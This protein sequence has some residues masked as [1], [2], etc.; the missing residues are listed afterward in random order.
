MAPK[1]DWFQAIFLPMMMMAWYS[2]N[3]LTHRVDCCLKCMHV[4]HSLRF[5][6]CRKSELLF[7]IVITFALNC[8]LMCEQFFDSIFAT[9]TQVQPYHT[10]SCVCVS[11]YTRTTGRGNN[12][13]FLRGSFKYLITVWCHTQLTGHQKAAKD[14]LL[15]IFQIS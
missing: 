2:K 7:G 5:T 4:S 14:H 3:F 15:P 13:W 6:E 8:E 12:V 1:H 9:T 10:I 11:C